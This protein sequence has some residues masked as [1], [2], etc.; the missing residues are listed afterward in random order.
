MILGVFL[1][2]WLLVG[3]DLWVGGLYVCGFVVFFFCLLI[4]ILFISLFV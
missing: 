3:F 1:F 2:E 4:Y